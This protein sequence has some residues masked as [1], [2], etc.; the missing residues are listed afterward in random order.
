VLV[1]LRSD[2]THRP[3]A[4]PGNAHKI[5]QQFSK[6][7][8]AL[9]KLGQLILMDAGDGCRPRL[10]LYA[11]ALI[12]PMPER[13]LVLTWPIRPV[14]AA[15]CVFSFTP[16]AGCSRLSSPRN[17]PHGRA[18]PAIKIQYP[19][20]AALLKRR[21]R[22]VASLLRLSGCRQNIDIAPH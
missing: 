11:F 20:C 18:T 17:H 12:L 5:T 9:M 13:Q 19:V 1:L 3:V 2:K 8:A 10:L 21:E 7:A 15:L 4:H 22:N 16:I 6:C 14:A